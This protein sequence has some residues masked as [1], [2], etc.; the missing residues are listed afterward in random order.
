MK[1]NK[2]ILN[3]TPIKI[4]DNKNVVSIIVQDNDNSIRKELSRDELL[5]HIRECR[6]ILFNL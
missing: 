6:L 1:N 4:E 2:V 5:S 3:V